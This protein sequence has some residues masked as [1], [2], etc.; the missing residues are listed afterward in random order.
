[1]HSVDYDKGIQERSQKAT[2]SFEITNYENNLNA[3][4]EHFLRVY[5]I[6]IECRMESS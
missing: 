4:Y 5:A 2:D 6:H 1:D 3:K